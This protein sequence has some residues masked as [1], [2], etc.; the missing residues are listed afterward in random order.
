MNRKQ[1]KS[2]KSCRETAPSH[3]SGLS[4]RVNRKARDRNKTTKALQYSVTLQP[5]FCLGEG[6]ALW[7]WS[8][9]LYSSHSP[10]SYMWMG[11]S[12]WSDSG[13]LCLLLLPPHRWSWLKI[14][15]PSSL[16]R[17]FS[18]FVWLWSSHW[19][20]CV[21]PNLLFVGVV[22][23]LGWNSLWLTCGLEVTATP[24]SATIFLTRRLVCVDVFC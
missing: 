23:S 2:S 8:L 22:L 19:S 5:L 18:Q 16:Y 1:Q 12:Q 6:S 13:G 11:L 14:S 17:C 10:Q 9:W 24:S 15:E 3:H 4:V 20:S 7:P 21:W